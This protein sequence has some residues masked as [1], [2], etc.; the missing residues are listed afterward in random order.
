[1][2]AC[3]PSA[4]RLPSAADGGTGG[5]L[6][7]RRAAARRRL[8]RRQQ[9]RPAGRADSVLLKGTAAACPLRLWY[10][11]GCR[12]LRRALPAHAPITNGRR[13]VERK[14]FLK[15][16]ALA[17]LLEDAANKPAQGPAGAAKGPL[18]AIRPV[19]QS[20][21]ARAQQRYRQAILLV[22]FLKVLAAVG[23]IDRS[24][25]ASSLRDEERLLDAIAVL[26]H[27]SFAQQTQMVT[28]GGPNCVA[29]IGAKVALRR[30]AKCLGGWRRIA[31]S[32]LN[33]QSLTAA[34]RQKEAPQ[35]VRDLHQ[36]STAL[37]LRK[38][39]K[40]YQEQRTKEA[41]AVSTAADARNASQ[42]NHQGGSRDRDGSHYYPRYG[43]EAHRAGEREPLSR[44]GALRE[45]LPAAD[46]TRRLVERGGEEGVREKAGNYGGDGV[47]QKDDAAALKKWHLACRFRRYVARRNGPA[48]VAQRRTAFGA[49][50]K[51][52]RLGRRYKNYIGAGSFFI[53]AGPTDAISCVE[54]DLTTIGAA[55]G[56]ASV[57]TFVLREWRAACRLHYRQIGSYGALGTAKAFSAWR[58]QARRW[59]TGAPSAAAAYDAMRC[60]RPVLY[61]WL[62]A[63]AKM[64]VRGDRASHH[65]RSTKK[66]AVL[67][68][69]HQK[70]RNNARINKFF[71]RWRSAGD[72][73]SKCWQQAAEFASKKVIVRALQHLRM[74]LNINV[75][76]TKASDR[77]QR[78]QGGRLCHGALA[79]WRQLR[80]WIDR[81]SEKVRTIRC[82]KDASACMYLWRRWRRTIEATRAMR[83]ASLKRSHLDTWRAARA[84]RALAR[85]TA[86]SV[87]E[88]WRRLLLMRR[89]L[90]QFHRE[91]H[92]AL[93][94]RG[95]GK[96]QSDS[97]AK[98][99]DIE[100]SCRTYL[101]VRTLH[102][103]RRLA[104]LSRTLEMFGVRR[105]GAAKASLFKGWRLD[106][107]VNFYLQQAPWRR[108]RRT[109][110]RMRDA[111]RA[112]RER[113]KA[114]G[115]DLAAYEERRR[116][117]C[118][119]RGFERWQQTFQA[120]KMEEHLCQQNLVS[121][122]DRCCSHACARTGVL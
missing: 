74:R 70:R 19:E 57:A 98:G 91:R 36:I 43:G 31:R 58:Q 86:G 63:L 61:A 20:A 112:S 33:R 69:W 35:V 113:H 106:A 18:S 101:M 25:T 104:S 41:A 24:S 55:A 40:Q 50:L 79:V 56:P 60:R 47:L 94:G 83:R 110:C 105:D 38:L 17:A 14:L 52:A 122:G 54:A 114:N 90:Y 6:E 15:T 26:S 81:N 80:S 76:L 89:A 78:R 12:S 48:Q 23:A 111:L 118:T 95:G 102:H 75:A 88:G 97:K 27:L 71:G 1:M 5:F 116:Y 99:H 37:R 28:N 119:F 11:P 103:W 2:A 16:I 93:Q 3:L 65:Y 66:V 34:S 82:A 13:W 72:F 100:L 10:G 87:M 62:A 44:W 51:A 115:G 46:A 109:L 7:G 64:Q 96:S 29:I 32:A 117:I 120:H 21:W 49:W 85:A 53:F 92:P 30:K 77:L 68:A 8:W 39:D 73:T 121:G 59:S 108:K 4:P 84:A 67:D 107:N 45:H 42:P 9:G 22:A